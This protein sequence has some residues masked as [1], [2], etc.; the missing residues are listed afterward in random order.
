[1]FN[2]IVMY[3]A[4]FACNITKIVTRLYAGLIILCD[5]CLIHS[6]LPKTKEI[7]FEDSTAHFPRKACFLPAFSDIEDSS[8]L[9]HI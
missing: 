2:V 1:M 4:V 9:S 7:L 5:L 8:D 3:S 6:A